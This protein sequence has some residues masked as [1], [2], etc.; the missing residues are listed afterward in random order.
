MKRKH[1]TL[2]LILC[3]FLISILFLNPDISNSQSKSEQIIIGDKIVIHSDIL[4]EDRTILIS[5]PKDYGNA[6]MKYPVLYILD[7]E[8]LFQQAIGAVNFLSECGYIYN[9]PIP[10]MIIVGIVN[11][12]RNRDYTPTHVPEQSG[13]L[14]YPT[15]GKADKFTEFLSSELIPHIESNYN[16][17]PYRILAGW[18]FGGL[19]A[20]HTFFENPNLFSAYLAIS[21]SL[22]WDNDMYVSGTDSILT[23][24]KVLERKLTLTLGTLEGGDMGRS[25]RDGFVPI[26]KEKLD[27]SFPFKFVEIPDE[28]HSFVPYKAIYEGLISIYSDWRMPNEIINEGFHA[29]KSFYK[30]LSKKYG[31][32]IQITEWAY[33]SLINTLNRDNKSTEALE[34]A[35]QYFLDYPKS[36]WTQLYLGRVYE[37]LNDYESAKHYYQKAIEFEKSKPEPDSERIITFTINLNDIE[38]KI[39]Q[40]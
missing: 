27:S 8:F 7:G 18:S 20:I 21:P 9:N 13:N 29:V 14:R 34:I 30:N 28:G 3:I 38:E 39:K 1:D 24:S 31:Y 32:D 40:R 15:S 36:S 35:K 10:Q 11:V 16:T 6:K 26:M 33:M 4:N 12:D 23:N 17:Q 37:R 19:F 2:T 25:V 5:L 22:W